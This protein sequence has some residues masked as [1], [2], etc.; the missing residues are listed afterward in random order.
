MLKV[1]VVQS[2]EKKYSLE[3][4]LC[5]LI[6]GLYT[7][8]NDSK[9]MIGLT[10]TSKRVCYSIV[11]SPFLSSSTSSKR[12]AQCVAYTAR[13]DCSAEIDLATCVV[14]L[15]FGYQNQRIK[16]FIDSSLRHCIFKEKRSSFFVIAFVNSFES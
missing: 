16:I 10:K 8:K 6:W 4:L 3:Q 1:P 2:N 11:S 14:C 13:F 12:I 9:S 5:K 7:S 15:L